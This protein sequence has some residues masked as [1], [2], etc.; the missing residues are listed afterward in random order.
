MERKKPMMEANLKMKSNRELFYFSDVA[1]K[2]A[3]LRK[4]QSESPSSLSLKSLNKFKY[5][6]LLE[7]KINYPNIKKSI[8]KYWKNDLP[9]LIIVEN[10]KSIPEELKSNPNLAIYLDVSI[11]AF[12]EMFTKSNFYLYENNSNLLYSINQRRKSANKAIKLL[13]KEIQNNN[14]QFDENLVKPYISK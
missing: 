8:K 9:E 1:V 12:N 3:L 10:E 4:S 5:V 6:V 7:S 11:E 2:I 14:Y 13:V